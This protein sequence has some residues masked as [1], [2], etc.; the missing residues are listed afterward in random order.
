MKGYLRTPVLNEQ[1]CCEF[2]LEAL[3]IRRSRMVSASAYAAAKHGIK[4]ILQFASM[5]P[6]REQLSAMPETLANEVSLVRRYALAAGPECEPYT[7]TDSVRLNKMTLVQTLL[8][9]YEYHYIS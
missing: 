9:S 2:I 7:L 8:N 4:E 6:L 1:L 3:S 5:V